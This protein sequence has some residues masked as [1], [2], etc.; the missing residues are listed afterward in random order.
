MGE[1]VD[2]D[3]AKTARFQEKRERILEAATLLINRHG[4]KGLTFVDVAEK[5]GL[6]TTSVTYYFRR[7]EMLA[8]AVLHRT[9]DRIETLVDSGAREA[10]PK[11]RV[12]AYVT[13]NFEL[14]ARILRGEDAPIAILSDIRA[15]KPPLRTELLDRY[16]LIFRKLR[17][18]FGLPADDRQ[19]ALTTA[20]AHALLQN[21]FWLIAWLPEYGAE[22]FDR[23]RDRLLEI[24]EHGFAPSG[25][26]W[27]PD[28]LPVPRTTGHSQ[29]MPGHYLRTATELINE[30][31]YR[32]ASVEDIVAQL[33]VTKG[34]FYHHHDAKD[35]L[36]VDCFKQ[37]HLRTSLV[38]QAGFEAPGDSLHRINSVIAT[39]LDVQFAGDF[40]LLRSTALQ[41]LPDEWRID[42]FEQSGRVARRFAG[43]LIDGISEGVIRPI[44]PLIASQVIMATLNAAY[45]L[46]KWASGMPGEEAV[47][48]YA[49]TLTQGL[50]AD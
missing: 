25:A 4:L 8:A 41:A 28:A 5:V 36:V 12:R 27:A 20:R 37:S 3:D 50:F 45:D 48:L 7:K 17:G 38:Q 44:D 9:L 14:H 18:Y 46:R 23:A 15:M 31:G 13:A 30:R 16:L 40:P 29:G 34:S 10:D 39:L 24:F 1:A 32:G 22:D 49:T 43:M 21:M 47:A 2:I 6:N 26:R 11:A 35:D 33:N 19:R 42:V